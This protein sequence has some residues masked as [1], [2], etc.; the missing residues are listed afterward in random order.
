MM[1]AISYQ[2]GSLFS[3]HDCFYSNKKGPQEP[4]EGA[5]AGGEGGECAAVAETG[6]GEGDEGAGAGA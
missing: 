4:G 3:D 2:Q 1:G 6:A 5:A